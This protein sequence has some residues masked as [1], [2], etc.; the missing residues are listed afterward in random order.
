MAH[1]LDVLRLREPSDE[2][3]VGLSED[4]VIHVADVLSGQHARHAVLS[5]LF[6]NQLD[7]VLCRR[8]A[9]VGWKVR[10]H[11]VHEE[12]QFEFP[13]GRLLR[14][15][16]V[17]ELTGEFLDEI[18]LLILILDGVEVD[19][20]EWNFPRNRRLDEGINVDGNAVGKEQLIHAGGKSGKSASEIVSRCFG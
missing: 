13:I 18:L 15:H 6:E 3:R 5:R 1:L 14:E 2:G 11:F 20:V 12:Q 10:R 4:F 16:P 19:D 17:V 9:R 8:I 7:E